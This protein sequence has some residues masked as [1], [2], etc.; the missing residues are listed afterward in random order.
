MALCTWRQTE[1]F[2]CP[3]K[4][5]DF[6]W[7]QYAF[8]TEY[9]YNKDSSECTS[10]GTLYSVFFSDKEYIVYDSVVCAMGKWK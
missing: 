5:L 7:S 2:K 1:I 9:A 4:T 6:W 10:N 8:D 3:N